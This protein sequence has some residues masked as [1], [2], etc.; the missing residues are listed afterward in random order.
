MRILTLFLDG[1]GLGK[2]DPE[3]NPFA[4]ADTPVMRRLA[5]DHRWLADTGFQRSAR[6]AFIPTDPRL[7]VPR[8]SPKRYRASEPAHRLKCSPVDRP[9]LRTKT[10]G[11]H[12]SNH[13][14]AQLLQASDATGQVR[15]RLL[16]A[17]PPGL[18]ANFDRG[19]TLRSSV[20]QAAYESGEP[21]FS[22]G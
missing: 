16:T 6:A 20:Q 1:I 2:D 11:Q 4:I 18:L 12:A 5:N 21:H 9:P 14:R 22:H 7:G 19:K 3:S 17:Y 8:S 10:R 13:S 15:K